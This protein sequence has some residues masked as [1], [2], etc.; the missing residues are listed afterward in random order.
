MAF[1]GVSLTTA[2]NF[3]TAVGDTPHAVGQLP[4]TVK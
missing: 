4:H 1:G 2:E 3:L